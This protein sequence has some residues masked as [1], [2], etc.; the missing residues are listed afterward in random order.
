MR[1]SGLRDITIVI[2]PGL[3]QLPLPSSV[4]IEPGPT[5]LTQTLFA[6]AKMAGF[7]QLCMIPPFDAQ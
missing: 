1:L 7:R 5:A 6:K 3:V 4:S 2:A